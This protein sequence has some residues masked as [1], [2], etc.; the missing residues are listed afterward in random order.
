MGA[1]ASELLPW[2]TI[3][4]TQDQW[5]G[6]GCLILLVAFVVFAFRKGM[7]VQKKPEGTPTDYHDKYGSP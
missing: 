7:D 5:I 3:A 6:L 4:M 1:V 2:R